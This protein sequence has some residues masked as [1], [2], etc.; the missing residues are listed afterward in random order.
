MAE[1]IHPGERLA[2][3][4]LSSVTAESATL[5]VTVLSFA[6]CGSSAEHLSSWR[7]FLAQLRQVLFPFR[8]RLSPFCPRQAWK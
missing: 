3:P 6:A 2:L 4:A 1:A 8:H 7:W 5:A